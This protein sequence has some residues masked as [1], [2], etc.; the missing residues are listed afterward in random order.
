MVKRDYASPMDKY[1]VTKWVEETY[2]DKQVFETNLNCPGL[3]DEAEK[4]TGK[5][6]SNNTMNRILKDFGITTPR[7]R[8]TI[9]AKKRRHQ[10]VSGAFSNNPVQE[11]RPAVSMEVFVRTIKAFDLRLAKTNEIITKIAEDLGVKID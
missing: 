8:A 3:C 9:A 2:V 11:E 10:D 5:R 7:M 1:A 6:V 4:A